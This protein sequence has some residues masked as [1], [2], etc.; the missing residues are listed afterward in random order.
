M[1]VEGGYVGGSVEVGDG[2][3][4]LEDA[5]VGTGRHVEAGHCLLEDVHGGLGGACGLCYH[6]RGHLGVAVHSFL[7]GETLALDVTGFDYTL[8]DG[9]GAFAYP[10]VP[11]KVQA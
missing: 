11:G 2:A 6:L 9:G 8:A 10:E 7:T 1:H 5:V 3:G 4:H